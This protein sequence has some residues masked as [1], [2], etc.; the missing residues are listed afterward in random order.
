MSLGPLEQ[1][2]PWDTKGIDGVHRFLRKFWRLFFNPNG[3][4]N[5]S[6]EAPKPEELKVLHK[7]IRKI[8]QDIES[9]PFN[10]SVSAF[11]IAVNA[12]QDLKCIQRE[13]LQ[14]PII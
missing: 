10:T 9:F 8:Q 12:L 6:Q 7:L 5:I 13:I 4:L 3:E 1:S 11:M 2:K 14:P